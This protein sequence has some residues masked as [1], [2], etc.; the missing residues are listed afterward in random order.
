M[1]FIDQFFK[2]SQEHPKQFIMLL[3][4]LI[5][6]GSI[7]GGIWISNLT[8]VLS[9]KDELQQQRIAV[10]HAQN[11][12]DRK[13]GEIRVKEKEL[14]LKHIAVFFYQSSDSILALVQSIDDDLSKS[15]PSDKKDLQRHR[16]M[17]SLLEARIH[18]LDYYFEEVS[19]VA[20]NDKMTKQ[21]V[22]RLKYTTDS[23]IDINY[24]RVYDQRDSIVQRVA[25]DQR[26]K[27]NKSSTRLAIL[28]TLS[29]TLSFL[30][31][32]FIIKILKV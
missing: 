15:Y 12:L 16:N 31:A 26:L 4:G 9:E 14:E 18:A 2:Y 28:I 6:I 8:G 27:D 23:L 24:K 11:D 25:V 21:N 20:S 19:G 30:L 17:L 13:A 10:I 5:M 29:L 22:L 3:L 32:Y 7:S 1:S